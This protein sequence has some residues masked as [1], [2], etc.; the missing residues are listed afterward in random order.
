MSWVYGE[1]DGDLQC[2]VRDVFSRVFYFLR[3]LRDA[4]NRQVAHKF[5]E[6]RALQ[7]SYHRTNFRL[8]RQV[9]PSGLH[10]PNP[11]LSNIQMK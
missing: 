7:R 9:T 1:S 3:V 10:Q 2:A 4:S 11:Q 6:A 8:T 5:E